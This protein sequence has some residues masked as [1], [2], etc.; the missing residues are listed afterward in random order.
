[1]VAFFIFG[2][3]ILVKNISLMVVFFA[4]PSGLVIGI[5]FYKA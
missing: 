1:M 3:H 4:L 2:I 5:C